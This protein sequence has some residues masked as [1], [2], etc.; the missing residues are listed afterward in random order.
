VRAYFHSGPEETAPAT[1]MG[2]D[3]EAR[4]TWCWMAEK[5]YVTLPDGLPVPEDDGAADHL[6]GMTVPAW[7]AGD[8]RLLVV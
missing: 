8:A 6:R 2:F 1:L 5:D 4:D 7:L 3:H